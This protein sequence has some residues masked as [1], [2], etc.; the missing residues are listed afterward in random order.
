MNPE[1]KALIH[2]FILKI[3]DIQYIFG[4]KIEAI[5]GDGGGRMVSYNKE[6]QLLSFNIRIPHPL[7]GN[8]FISTLSYVEKVPSCL[9]KA[10]N[11]NSFSFL[12]ET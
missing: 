4:R 8:I 11:F 1:F 10:K 3:L 12:K 5:K 9:T 6:A 7:D 2:Y